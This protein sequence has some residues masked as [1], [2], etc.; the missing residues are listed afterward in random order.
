MHRSVKTAC[1]DPINLPLNDVQEAVEPFVSA[2]IDHCAEALGKIADS[3]IK[4]DLFQPIS[5]EMPC[6]TS[7]V[8]LLRACVHNQITQLGHARTACHFHQYTA[9]HLE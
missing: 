3:A 8:D 7:I 1:D 2:A 6:S 9:R 4:M 5:A